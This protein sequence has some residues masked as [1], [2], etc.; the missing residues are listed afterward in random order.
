MM[1]KMANVVYNMMMRNNGCYMHGPA[2]NECC[3]TDKF[4]ELD[5]EETDNKEIKTRI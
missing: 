1:K 4:G 2:L 5:L 3:I